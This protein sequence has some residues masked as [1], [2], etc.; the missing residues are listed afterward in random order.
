MQEAKAAIKGIDIE[1][2]PGR[3]GIT[4]LFFLRSWHIIKLYMFMEVREFSRSSKLPWALKCTNITL[5]R[6]TP[7]ASLVSRY[8][9]ISYSLVL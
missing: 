4:S 7:H 1:S 6:K 3:D 8:M 9:S 5:T 2:A